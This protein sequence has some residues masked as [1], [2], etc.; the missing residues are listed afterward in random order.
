MRRCVIVVVALLIGTSA[1][2]MASAGSCVSGH[3]CSAGQFVLGLSGGIV[4]P[5]G[6]IGSE[7][8]W[9]TTSPTS[10]LDLRYGW[11]GSAEASLYLTSFLSAGPWIGMSDLRMRDQVL[12][13]G[14]AGTETFHMLVRGRTAFYGVHVKAFLPSERSWTPY[15]VV[16]IARVVR[17][18]D[19][20][21]SIVLVAPETDELKVTDDRV[22][23]D[24]GLG[25]EQAISPWLGFTTCARYFYSGPLKHD[26][27]WMGHTMPVSS[28]DFWSVDL[29]FTLH[30]PA[31]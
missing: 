23:F 1:V 25:F 11:N 15:A 26:L 30:A 7:P 22:G 5:N 29:G 8:D 6:Q 16:G 4:K 19:L 13:A 2:A 18:V 21:P 24:A 27:Q 14:E 12:S 10:G 20:S 28:W 3:G 9:T 31:R 17:R